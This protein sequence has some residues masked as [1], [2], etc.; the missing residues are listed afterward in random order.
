MAYFISYMMNEDY[1]TD[2]LNHYYSSVNTILY[3]SFSDSLQ[4]FL[5]LLYRI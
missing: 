2:F 1:K 5:G 3:L 4:T